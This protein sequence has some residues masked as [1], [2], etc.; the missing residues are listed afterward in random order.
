MTVHAYVN[1]GMPQLRL[2]FPN[3]MTASVVVSGDG[4]V[5]LAYWPTHDDTELD[6]KK[7]TEEDRERRAAEVVMGNQRATATEAM[8]WLQTVEA[9]PKFEETR[10]AV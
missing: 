5:A 9:L 10:D 7:F 8:L 4:T 6:P 1:N 3:N 2:G